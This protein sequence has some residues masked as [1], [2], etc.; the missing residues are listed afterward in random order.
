MRMKSD[1][2]D[3]TKVFTLGP[4]DYFGEYS[5]LMRGASKDCKYFDPK[6]SEEKPE[7]DEA[8]GVGGHGLGAVGAAGGES[9]R[10]AKDEGRVRGAKR[11]SAANTS[12]ARFAR[13]LHSSNFIN[14]SVSAT[15]FACRRPR[16]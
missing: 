3:V 12:V 7:E 10:G 4:G 6:I 13:R 11:R 9:A 5:M 8:E 14:T 1:E 16:R 2:Q 15:R